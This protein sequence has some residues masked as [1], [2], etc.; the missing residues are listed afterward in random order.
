M[1]ARPWD[2]E[3]AMEARLD[4]RDEQKIAAFLMA[5]DIDPTREAIDRMAAAIGEAKKGAMELYRRGL[6]PPADS[7]ATPV[8]ARVDQWLK[9]AGSKERVNLERKRAVQRFEAWLGAM[10]LPNAVEQVSR[11][12]AGL[13]VSEALA[14]RHHKT[15]AKQVNLLSG[16]WTHLERK[17]YVSSN[18]WTRQAPAKPRATGEDTGKRPYTD[19][20]IRTLLDGEPGQPLHDVIRLLDCRA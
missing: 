5:S 11:K 2:A 1:R 17:G 12:V 16:Y 18:P 4:S 10:R 3:A 8:G 19:A 6:T 7:A 14:G 20:E 13:Y 9:E 15:A